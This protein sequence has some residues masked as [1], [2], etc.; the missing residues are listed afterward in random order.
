[1]IDLYFVF[2][3]VVELVWVYSSHATS[4]LS[5]FMSAITPLQCTLIHSR[6]GDAAITKGVKAVNIST[7]DP[8][9]W[10]SISYRV[11]VTVCT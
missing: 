10:L 11:R 2:V 6:F 4:N 7:T 9:N 5:R 8:T 3:A 1:M